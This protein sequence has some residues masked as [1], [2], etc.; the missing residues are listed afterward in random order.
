MGNQARVTRPF[1][2]RPKYGDAEITAVTDLLR[3][4]S[5]SEIG[6]GPAAAALEDAFAELTGTTHAGQPG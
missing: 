4:G 1:P 3:S 2:R 5:L 6:R